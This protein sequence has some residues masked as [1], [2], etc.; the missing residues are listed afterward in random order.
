LRE[1]QPKPDTKAKTEGYIKTCKKKLGIK[2][3]PKPDPDEGKTGTT[4]TK[5]GNGDPDPAE[6]EKPTGI[7]PETGLPY[8]YKD[9][10]GGESSTGQSA[11]GMRIA[12]WVSL[13]L[14][15]AFG[16]SGTVFALTANA[17]EDDIS[18]LIDFRTSE[19]QPSRYEGALQD[20]YDDKVDEGDRYALLSK[21]AFGAAG[22]AAAATLVFFVIDGMSDDDGSEAEDAAGTATIAPTVT[23]NGGVGISAGWR[24]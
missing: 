22:V 4:E 2:D 1:S 23:P 21:V 9:N 6:P 15:A 14:A 13:G 20:E 7:D 19:G 8:G 5:T 24:F 3:E 12:G 18:E 10:A 16:A 17:R 11:S